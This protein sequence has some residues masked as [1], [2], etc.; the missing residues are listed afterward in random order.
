[1]SG[2]KV[3]IEHILIEIPSAFS[4]HCLISGELESRIRVTCF[5]YTLGTRGVVVPRQGGDWGLR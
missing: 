3:K 4:T 5:C 2:R 1:M